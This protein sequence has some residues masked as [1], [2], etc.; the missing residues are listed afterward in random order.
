MKKLVLIFASALA[1]A[2]VSCQKEPMTKTYTLIDNSSGYQYLE[3]NTN[4][5]YEIEYIFFINE[6]TEGGLK[7]NTSTV[8][9]PIVGKEYKFTA[10]EDAHHLTVKWQYGIGDNTNVR[11][12]TNAF[13]LKEGENVKI[14]INQDT[15]FQKQEPK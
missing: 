4:G 13:L 5:T 14:I 6:Y 15:Y 9:K 11:Y 3:N 2:L 10:S 1:L 8:E 7:I 12:L